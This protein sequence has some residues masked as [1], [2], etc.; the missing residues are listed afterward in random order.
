M[1]LKYSPV[2][3]LQQ[4]TKDCGRAYFQIKYQGD[5][6]TISNANVAFTPGD[7]TNPN[8]GPFLLGMNYNQTISAISM[9]Y[10]YKTIGN[11]TAT[12]VITSAISGGTFTLPLSVVPGIYGVYI[13]ILPPNCYPGM[14]FKMQVF[15]QQGYDVTLEWFV[16]GQSL[17]Q[18]KRQCKFIL[19]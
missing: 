19:K 8:L 3:Y 10:D 5:A 6:S 2:I 18:S 16:N 7:S 9:F 11:Y 4:S 1:E 14:T 12:F 15:I 13:Q 17:G